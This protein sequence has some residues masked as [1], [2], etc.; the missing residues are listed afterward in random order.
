V[1]IPATTPVTLIFEDRGQL[2]HELVVPDLDLEVTIRPGEQV[3]AV[4]A[5]APV[6]VYRWMCVLPDHQSAGIQGWLVAGGTIDEHL[7]HA[8]AR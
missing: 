1:H 3:T 8:S 2:T 5:S 7:Q 4:I 6:G